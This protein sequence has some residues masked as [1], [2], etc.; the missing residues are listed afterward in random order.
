MS[1]SA[2]GTF[3][4]L[5]ERTTSSG[6]FRENR[7]SD[8]GFRHALTAVG[9]FAAL[10]FSSL[11]SAATSAVHEIKSNWAGAPASASYGTALT[12]EWHI[13]TNDANNPQAKDPVNNV[14]LTL[15]ATNGVFPSIP[16]LCKT[17][18]VTPPSAISANGTQL[19]CN[20]GTI[21][22]GTA[23]VVQATVMPTGTVGSQLSTS[24]V[25]TS[26]SAAAATPPSAT[27]GLTIT[28][29]HGMDLVLSAS[30][31][32]EL[33]QPSRFGG[34]RQNIIVDYGIA[35]TAGSIA[36]PSTYTFTVDIS[37]SVV[38]QLP[39]LQWE[40]CTPVNDATPA[41]GIPYS[42]SSFTNRTNA[43]TCTISGS[44]THYTVTLSGLDYSLQHV[45]T[46]D[47][48]G[49]AIPS[50]TNFIAAG[51]LSFSYT[52][53]I[54]ATTGV[55]FTATPSTFTFIDSVTQPET[56][57][58]N[59]A[60]G[61]TLTI[62]GIFSISWQGGPTIGRAP[63]D[64][65]LWGAPGTAQNLTLPWPGAGTSTNP[66]PYSLALQPLVSSADSVAWINYTGAGGADVAG[67]CSMV[68]NPAAFV[69]RYADFL[70]A[71]VNY[72]LLKSAHLWYRTDA[73]N[74]KTETC[75]EPVGVAGSPWTA[76]PLPAG[77]AS[78]TVL[79]SPA[80]S[81][82]QCLVTLPA[83]VTAVKMT[84][85]PAVDT[86]F[87]HFL[88]VWGYVPT[89]APIG[90]ESWTV[91]AFN[92]PN[93]PS[94][95]FPGFPT[96]N[97][98]VN[99][100]TSTAVIAN[101]PGSTYG[102]NTNGMRD[103]MRIQGPNGVI[104][105][106]AATQTA[107]P[108]V[109]VTFNLSAESDV[110][111]A[112]PPAQTFTVVDTLPTGMTYVAGSG[113]PVPALST[114]GSG[115]QVLTYTFTSVPA[116]TAQPITYQAQTAANS[117]VAPGTVLTNTAQVNV[118]GDNRPAAAKQVSA[119]VTV[120]SNGATTMGKSVESSPL[121]F[122]GDSS[123]WDVTIN[124]VDSVS[125]AFTDTID[126]LPNAADGRGTNISGTYT[127]TGVT[128]PAGATVYYSS[129]AIGSLSNDPRAASNGGTPGSIVGNS[130]GWT[131]TKPATPTAIRV[132]GPALAPG[133]AQ[134]IRI[135]FT[136]PAGTSCTAPASTDNKP[137]QLLVNSANTIAE[138]TALPMLASA[139][140]TIGNC[141]ALDIKKYVLVK[142]GNPANPS[143]YHDANIPTDYQQY[144]VGD[145]IPYKIV[146]TNSGTG[147]LT[148]ISVTD[149]IAP[150]C[151]FIVAS[152]AVG[153]SQTQTC[154][155]TASAAGTLINTA[156][157]STTPP[158]GPALSPG[159]VA[160]AVVTAPTIT[161]KKV[162][163]GTRF[164]AADQ[165]TVAI[166]TGSAGGTVVNS[167]ANSTTTGTGS[168]VTAGT[169]TT[170]TYT[171]TV[172]TTYYLTEA[173]SGSTPLS[174][175]NTNISCTDLN[176]V[177]T[178][179]PNGAFSGSATVTPVNGAAISCTLTNA[180]IGVSTLFK[181]AK[182]LANSSTSDSR[183]STTGTAVPGDTI[184]WVV[185]YNNNTGSNATVNITDLI[186]N[187]QIYVP[188][189]LKV[190]PTLSMQY[191]TNSGG[192][193]TTGTP[194]AGANGIGALTTGSNRVAG[195]NA[196]TSALAPP[197]VASTLTFNTPGGDGY[198]VE[199]FG[200]AI[201]TVFHHSSG[202]TVVFCATLSNA[203]CPG[204]PAFS[205]YVNPTA[206]TPIGTGGAGQFTT[207][208]VNGSFISNGLLYWPVESLT[209]VGGSY[210]VGLQC[211]NLTTL[212]SCGFTQLDTVALPP[213]NSSYGGIAGDGIAAANGNHY[214][215][216]LNGN[217]LCFNPATA[218]S[219]GTT[220]AG[221]GPVIAANFGGYFAEVGTYGNY[222]Y[223]TYTT[224]GNA[225]LFGYNVATAT[226]TLVTAQFVG[227][228]Q[229]GNAASEVFPVLSATGAVLG[230]CSI[231]NSVCYSITNTAI[232]N[233]W[234]ATRF[235]FAPASLGFG[236]GVVMGSKYYTTYGDVTT[237]CYDFAL[238]V[239]T[240][241]VPE[242]GTSGPGI[243]SPTRGPGDLQ[244]YT[245]RPL[246]NLPGCMAD[247]GNGAQIVV[248]NA[249]TG[250]A[251][252]SASTTV[253]KTTP[254]SFYCDGGTH[255]SNWDKLTLVGLTGSEYASA[256]VTLYDTN[257]N[258]VP[259]FVNVVMSGTT[260]DISSLVVSGNYTALAASVTLTGVTNTAAVNAASAALSWTG[261]PM[262]M[263][264][265]TVVPP[266]SCLTTAPVNDVASV[267]T[268]AGSLTDGPAGTSSGTTSFTAA[269]TAAQC[270][271]KFA[272]TPSATVVQPGGALTYTIT[273]TNNGTMPYSAAAPASFT[274]DL[275]NVLAG[276]VYSDN[277]SAS[278]GTA[279]YAAP[280]LSWS[281]PLAAG[282]TATIKYTVTA[283]ANP[284]ASMT[285][286]VVTPDPSNCPSGACTAI[287]TP[288]PQVSIQ[289]STPT[290]TLTPGGTI[291][292][293]IVVSNT[294]SVDAP[295]TAVTDPIPAGIASQTWT[296]GAAGG[297]ACPNANG[298][299][300]LNETL[301]TFP[302]GSV[303]T[304][305]VTATIVASP[306][307][308]VT[309][310]A[311]AT[312]PTGSV[313][314][315]NNTPPPCKSTVTVPPVPQVSIQKST[316]ATTLTPNGTIVYTIVA[317][318]TGAV[319]ATGTVVADPIPTGIASQTWT[320]AASGGAACPNASGSGSL[321][322]TLAT[323]P[324]GS[325]VTYTVTATVSATPPAQVTNTATAT[326][327]TPSLCTPNNTPPPCKS[328]VTVPPVPQIGIVKS[329]NTAT[330]TPDGTVVYTIVVSNTGTVS[331]SGTT[332]ADPIPTG[333]ASQGWNCAASGG[334]AC[335]N[336][337][338]TGALNETLATF[339]A[340]SSVTYTVTATVNANPPAQVTNTATAT[341]PSGGVC[342][343]GNNAPPCTS[344][345]TLTPLPQISIQ[346]STPATTLT[347]GG[348]IVYTIAASNTGTVS[349]AGSVVADPIPTG[350]ASQ[351]WTCSAA[352]GAACPNAS[353]A[354]ALNETLATFPA[355][356]SVTYTV[357]ATV[358][359]TPP[360]HVTN[361]ATAT[362]PTGGLCTPG[363]TQPPCH[364]T[365]TV[366]PVPQVSIQ[367]STP[368]TTLT[369][370][371]TII[372]TIVVDNTG[373]VSAAGTVV[374]DPI[375][376]GIAGQA[377]TCAA[378]GGAICPNAVGAGALNETLATFPAGSSVTYT[379]TATVSANPPA[380]VINTATATPPTG[381]VCTPD[382]T[383]P[384][385]HSTVTVPPVPQ[386]SIQKSTPATTLTPGGTIVYTIVASNTGAVDANGTQVSDPIPTGIASQTWACS[387]SGGAVCPNANGTGSLNET[388][389]TFPAGSSVTYTVTATVSANPPAHVTNTATATPPTVSV[390]T[391]DN[392]QPPCHSTVVVPPVPQISIQ[393]ST[394]AT[395]V[396]PNGTIVYTIV[397]SNEGTVD[398]SGTVVSDPIPT[399]IASQTWT[400]AA[401]GGAACPNAS[402]SGSLNETLATFPAGSSVTYTVTATVDANPP[403]HVTNTATGTLTGSV[404]EPNNTP[405]PCPS[406]VTVPPVP[407]IRIQKST[408][409]TT[410][411][412]GG[413]IVYTIV[414]SNEGTVDASG[415]VVADA[416]P[417][418][419]ASQTWTCAAGGGAA[420]PNA[421][422][423]GNLSETLAL[424]PAGGSVTYTV[425]A[426]VDANPPAHV[427]N[428]ATGTL[429]GSVCEPDN[430]PSPCPSTV[431]VPPVP[432]VN[433]QKSTP[434]TT[435]TPGGTITYTI[436]AS[437]TGSVSAAGS[438]V[439]DPIPTG[440]ASQT[441]TCAASS[442][443]V[444]PNASGS[445]AL[446]E[447]L[448]TFPA[449]SFV[450]YTVTATVSAT[451]PA[452]VTNTATLTPPTGSV[453]TPGNTAPPCNSTVTV[454]PVPQVNI[455]KSTPATTL[456]PGGTITYTIVASNT[457]AVNAN[458]TVVADPIP[459][460]IASQTWTCAASGGAVCPN[461]N[462]SGSLSETL[463]TFPAGSA[464]TYTVTATVVANPPA[465]VTN[466]ATATPPTPSVCTP[467]NT[468]PPCHSTVVV[469]P[470]P[471]VS[472]QKS[473]PTTT[474]T[475]GGTIVY[476][477][478]A[479]NTGSVSASGT[480]VS[481]PIPA[482]IASQTWTCSAVSGGAS[483]PNPS[484]SG[485]LNETLVVFPGGSSV[486]YTVTAI[487]A[488]NP[489]AHVTNTATATPPIGSVCTPDNTQPPCNSTVVVPPYPQVSIVKSTPATTLT[490]N[491]SIVYTIVAS[492]TG[493]VSADGTVVA[494]PIPTGIAS[495]TWTCAASGGAVCPN[496]NGSGALSETVATFP[497]GGAVTY[498]VTATVAAN[499][500]AHV[501]NTATAA[502]P[503]GSL[504]TPNNTPPPCS[505]TVTV[506]PVPQVSI[507]KSTT[508]TTLTPS[509]S[510]IY[511][512]VVS[513]TGTVDAAGTAVADPI[514]A[515]IASQ[516]WACTA[517][518]GAA[519]PNASGSGALNETL[520]TFPA[521]SVVTYTVTAVVDD[522]PPAHVTNTATATP[523]TGGV[524]EPNNTT[525]PCN[526]TVI[527]PPVPQIG[528]TKMASTST[529]IPGGTVIYTV[530]VTNTGSVDADA[531][532]VSD[533]I[534]AG[535]ASQ[536]WTCSAS[537]GGLCPNAS[538]S[539]AL[540][541][542]LVTFDPGNVVTYTITATVSANP[543]AQVI[544][545]ATATPPTGGVCTPG[546][547]APPCKATVTGAP[548]P[549]ISIQKST[550]A[551]TLTPNG[552]IVYTIV[553]S[554]AG[555][556]SAAGTVVADPMPAGIASQTW[557]CSASGG[558][559]CPNA[560][561]SGALNE[562]LATFPAGSAVTYTVTATV[563]ANP[564]AHVTNTATATP[565]TGGL[566]LPNNT[567]PPC[568]SIVVVPPVPQIS[569]A[570]TANTQTLTPGGTIVYTV[571]A[572]NSGTVDAAGTVVSD[573]IPAGITAVS[574][575]C[576][577]AGGA[578][579]PNASGNGALNQTLAT[580]PAGST[581]T[582]TLTATVSANPPA[583]VTNT[584][585]ATPP[586]GGLC[587]PDN[588]PPPCDSI[589]IVPPVP[590]VSIAKSANTQTLTPGGTIV[591]T[592][593][594]SNTG[595]VSAA[596]TVVSDPIPTGI[597]SQT[598]TCAPSGGAVC[599]NASGSGALNETLATFPAGSTATYTVTA[600][601][602]ANPP[603]HV[604]N[605]ATATPPTG[606]LCLP[607]N[608]PPPC[609]SIVTVPPVP[610]VSI[611]KSTPATTLT[612][613]GTIVYTIVASN[614]GTV[615]AAG[616]V[617]SD[618]IPTGIASQSWTCA[619]S[620]GAACP[621][622]SGTGSL[623]ETLA[624][625]PAGSAVTYTVTATVSANPPAQVTNTATATPPTG[626][627]CLP[628]NTPP[629][630]Q[631]IV[632]VPPV[633][634][635]SIHKSTLATTLTPNGTV[636]YTI[637]ASN[638]GT[639]SAAGTV[640]SDPIPVGI[641]SQ[642]WTCAASGG[643]ACPNA[644]GAGS[645]NETL[646]T[647]PAGSTVT[648]TVTATV[649]ATP[650][651]QVTNTATATPPTGGLCLP[652]NTPP[653]C[654][655]IVTVPPVP[656]V[657]IR[658]STPATTLTPNGTI[659]YTIV[660]SN[661]GTVSAAGTVVSDPIPTGIASQ[662]WTCA[663]SGGAACP[664]ASGS[665]NLSET[666]ATF[667]GGSTVTYTVTATVVANP[668]AQV[669]NTAT[670]TP[671]PGSLC[672]PNNT[673]PPCNSI[674][675][676]PPVPQV[677]VV[678][679]SNTPTL[680]PGG[681]IVYTVTVTNTGTVP[682]DN[683][684]VSDPIAPGLTAYSTTC[685]AAGGAVC[686]NG[687]GPRT[688]AL[689]ETIA[690]L[691]VGG[692]VVY[693]ITATVS[694]NPAGAVTNTASVTPPSGGLCA[695][696]N[697]PPPCTSTTTSP[698]PNSF[699]PPFI[700]KAATVV[701][702]QTLLW[703]VVVDNNQN[704]SAQN[705]E[706]RD[707]MP[708]SMTFVSGT[709]TCTAF[710][711]TTISQCKFDAANN[712]VVVDTL[713]Q[714]DFGV[715]NPATGPNRIAIAFQAR[716]VNGPVAVTNIASACWD[717]QNNTTNVTAC[718]QAVQGS[719]QYTPS[720]PPV[721]TPIDARWMLLL[722]AS[723]LAGQ[724]ASRLHRRR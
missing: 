435:L 227:A 357:T 239:G 463:A 515:G 510:V 72:T 425:T 695:P 593:V 188:G 221:I 427:T 394:P 93:N 410:L 259:G 53:A 26:D 390:C 89:T 314:T 230:G 438:V 374:S 373:S 348:T 691:P 605:T 47:S 370:G 201:Y 332:V 273:V 475:P 324:A 700:T 536:T 671:P 342:T 252:V 406:T 663:A 483:C 325:S 602:S 157:A 240:G 307:A 368:D 55:T 218:S 68:Q 626:G 7:R 115:Q 246:A 179:L 698:P 490:P 247:N 100:S 207:A 178:G 175:Y 205:T 140:T 646:A 462:G 542:T 209:A 28:G 473:T 110:T 222:L 711:S 476:T 707:P 67:L 584:A 142:G 352:G 107:L 48:L 264:Y 57:T 710:G 271:L 288:T 520:A 461:A 181:N 236:S 534:P 538:G 117:A 171:A 339:P 73:L 532:V 224:G 504:C 640:V 114:N 182:N 448:A 8:I 388:L 553:A 169:G 235:G 444:C 653:P 44:G 359:A 190:P 289:K 298:A 184:Q 508:T 192:T 479:S 637:V 113:T 662:T 409:T 356:S 446:N 39:G 277:L 723:L 415:T 185:N 11:A 64:A 248:F 315:P 590:Q 600:T 622:A 87:H 204:W 420:C 396:T 503:T 125:N 571:V 692:R 15:T 402:G 40:G 38:G 249:S 83:G 358:S 677:G 471:Q 387:A 442:G 627:L 265:Q 416:M 537:G 397:A 541:E 611:H 167:T 180:S 299:G 24:G 436:V 606:G 650:P 191:T 382:N 210:P 41:L 30:S 493:S 145:T 159:D 250:G 414:A 434:A 624:T 485:A 174:K 680:N 569:I 81:D 1:Q 75:G 634:Q 576:A 643:A 441:W 403:A 578:A 334:A 318:N 527:V 423:S 705:L 616:T 721:P 266:V 417:T 165:F 105:K 513:N 326:P 112:S 549:Q 526:S 495:Q 281:G 6:S 33:N 168:T 522:V 720:T 628:N 657:S 482:G 648:Y 428:T 261:D 381:S 688:G 94:L 559:A 37:V 459:A 84:W 226:P 146:I 133:A 582:Y 116:N 121:S 544:N 238:R 144:F 335:P 158:S 90:A 345:V 597:A 601:V 127:I 517:S 455:Q 82:D 652:N 610:Q 103:A 383:P 58:S 361:T 241:G 635:V 42:A 319:A 176:N 251:C 550:P 464:V 685:A 310:T 287:V 631:S 540:N 557:T 349:A 395:T 4:E 153:V 36:G 528:I 486:T 679:T 215:V 678:K 591:Y 599:P 74:T 52:T 506:P 561:G 104:S 697:T 669:T 66:G 269:P 119:S 530:V 560:T 54:T 682:A 80:Y 354:G 507:Q 278:A 564:P 212:K 375:P 69:P 65:N 343:P 487:V 170:G 566:C 469:P 489:P 217:L 378:S 693:T 160:G 276:A 443:A 196:G 280:V 138:H 12:S 216:D 535:I 551:T 465:Q 484:G 9:L 629:P 499:P 3:I 45:P 498:T 135:A 118:T 430:T 552:T 294:G 545:T 454:P 18:G 709:L 253:T 439:S 286:T 521:G 134:T 684:Q 703:T 340:G 659:V 13:N 603:A 426:T 647:F 665:G 391:P 213:A 519:C 106:T 336:A 303:V 457:G 149:A 355:S 194:P 186:T 574:W 661:T 656:Q 353:G 641:S 219:C 333:I 258:P 164:A 95:T 96:L 609:E 284:P 362:P 492:N 17:T 496:A 139:T 577:A 369:P 408:I 621:N 708:S 638:T 445:G 151:N 400:C 393:K 694:A 491:G 715:A 187:G 297:A 667:P 129:A 92:M 350:I 572:T 687:P 722:L 123:A 291:V 567:P 717:P 681:T 147:A 523:P 199:G 666:L 424:F 466:T 360:A 604:T 470:V 327:P 141:Y 719:A 501:V 474:L 672:T 664:H 654:E 531:T 173:I 594:A 97:N 633:P 223:F 585:T 579:C 613:N 411:T 25:V 313:C 660:A 645:L 432:Q 422:G 111:T 413:T 419:I 500:P 274:D 237:L 43:P 401:G 220:N 481:D 302:A 60:S 99:V 404:C 193:W 472:I 556:V 272:K 308:Q 232:P 505:S 372:Y 231:F 468:Q 608:T 453:C 724:A 283:N 467:D 565:P 14:R 309:N 211:L 279:A 524:C 502:P 50:T 539:G 270:T 163:A 366:P 598:W 22:E 516:T 102:P 35:M 88:R 10:A 268:T 433:I 587:L 162:L 623:N 407:Q 392:T 346:K 477:I 389:A 588:T 625:F 377:W 27:P 494:D 229:T 458:G 379:V 595:T 451:P 546:N 563:S 488:A 98:Y 456:T 618:P 198:S 225:Y 29:S 78:Q 554:N 568:D 136:T 596:G 214:Y 365:V 418:G 23:T 644:S 120:P 380:H 85:D 338:G 311:T 718:A 675:T 322:E 70:G 478:V 620:G 143:D 321:S 699:D 126:I 583:H 518:G 573:P 543:P 607:N 651:A 242:C 244:S 282:A 34:N 285:N 62:P 260:L 690:T 586:T 20:L 614:T 674:V 399:G 686:P 150:S 437:N 312:P 570:K 109:P 124:S 676:V 440:I 713:M 412:P 46:V 256:T 632:T 262:Q 32:Q 91:G 547:T 429:T 300:G 330:A 255:V 128:A 405:S 548:V 166:R 612:P 514:P 108:G 5:R 183:T 344:T 206:G 716:F 148:N 670:A 122:Y 2:C 619:A 639:V 347:P 683:T 636:V 132:I 398:A 19:L 202:A 337:S 51:T 86:Q 655:S 154:S 316:P 386:V 371:G 156:I 575:T 56:N 449:G 49:N 363:N 558:A 706:I 617:V 295:G 642:T 367:K 304:Y 301:A 331:A 275:T 155:T 161:L 658:K 79:I 197:F 59:D 137:G 431:T 208:G 712:R 341:P 293:T 328:I 702:A 615:D 385:C 195:V 21:L 460:G 329:A 351:T 290:T 320:C 77:C 581:V 696:N 243:A 131:T 480:V 152:L 668:P 533:P 509:G 16:A 234:P 31:A 267:V 200:N 701:D 452:Q 592:V 450:T 177:Q 511:T 101:I 714:S 630:C 76:L 233:P 497:A 317:S 71:D 306:P 130:V 562:T 704:Q 529:L 376:T 189:S 421:S 384:P 447:T 555:S 364:S 305:T 323:F 525:P 257:G 649:S 245:V 589:V 172:G 61:T 254:T 292:Y 228:P 63:W 263:C 296:C 512:I 673:P 689:N 580:F 203:I